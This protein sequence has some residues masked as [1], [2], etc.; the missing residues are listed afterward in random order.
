MV[1]INIWAQGEWWGYVN[2]TR[3]HDTTWLPGTA[4]SVTQIT[5]EIA[6]GNRFYSDGHGAWVTPG[7]MGT[8]G[9]PITAATAR[10]RYSH[11]GGLSRPY[12]W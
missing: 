3:G 7:S 8:N 11:G 2:H 12:W 1:D 4:L 9:T 10:C 5:S 6:G